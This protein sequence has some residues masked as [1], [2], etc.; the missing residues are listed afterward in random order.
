M[1]F[2]EAVMQTRYVRLFCVSCGEPVAAVLDPQAPNSSTLYTYECHH[3]GYCG[4]LD[5]P[6]EETQ[7]DSQRRSSEPS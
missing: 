5:M 3:C 1:H 6:A 2:R 7:G 4:T